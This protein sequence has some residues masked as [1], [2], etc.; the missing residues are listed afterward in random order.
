MNE[1]IPLDKVWGIFSSRPACR[2]AGRISKLRLDRFFERFG[3]LELRHAH[4]GDLHRRTS[5]RVAGLARCAHLGLKDAKA[6][7]GD[8]V[9][10][11]ELADDRVYHRLN[12]AL[13]IRLG[14]SKDSVH[15][16]CY[17]L[18]IHSIN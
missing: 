6:G 4:R 13:G 8:V 10:F 15:P 9:A 5:A 16:F 14:G 1:K 17:I 7:D 12:S 11:L 3:C 18:F 2:R